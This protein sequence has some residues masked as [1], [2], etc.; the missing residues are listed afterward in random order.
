MY[1]TVILQYTIKLKFVY[2]QQS[3]TYFQYRIARHKLYVFSI[4]K[5]F[6][7]SLVL[8]KILFFYLCISTPMRIRNVSMYLRTAFNS[9]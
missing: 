9:N 1:V 6:A 4:S 5:P 8:F 2:L 7:V 3:S